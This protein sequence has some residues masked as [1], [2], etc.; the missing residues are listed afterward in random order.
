V[1]GNKI[2]PRDFYHAL[3]EP[4]IYQ[5]DF[6]DIGIIKVI[7]KG[8]KDGKNA[9]AEIELIDRFDEQTGL[10]AMQRLTGWHSSAIAILAA[11]G[12]IEK[13]ALPV[14][15]AVPGNVIIDEMQTRGLDV[16]Q[17]FRFD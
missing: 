2:V 14:E 3:L 8:K 16:K 4:K 11:K 12:D 9:S 5:E 1:N 15:K 10:T 7:A 6:K 17:S 13:G